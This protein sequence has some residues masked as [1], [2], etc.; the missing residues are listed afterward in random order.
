MGVSYL[1]NVADTRNS[2][3]VDLIKNLIEAGAQVTVHDPVVR[4]WP[5]K[6]GIV[7]RSDLPVC[8]KGADGVVFVVAHDVY[9]RMFANNFVRYFSAKPF[10]VDAQNIITDEN[11]K[12]LHTTGCRLS[13]VG[14][15]H[16]LKLGYH[17]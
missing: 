5:G 13:G 2:P 12:I 15:G 8:L 1:P 6:D 3:S 16:W 7:I 14:K 4:Q 9:R 11:A 10:I 17:K